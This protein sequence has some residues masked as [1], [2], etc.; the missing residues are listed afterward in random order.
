MERLRKGLIQ[1]GKKK[2][3]GGIMLKRIG[4]RELIEKSV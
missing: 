2:R 4:E 3:M 1:K